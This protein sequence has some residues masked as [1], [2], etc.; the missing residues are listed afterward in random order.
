MKLLISLLVLPRFG[1][2]A[3][4]FHPRQAA[5]RRICLAESGLTRFGVSA[6]PSFA[7]SASRLPQEDAPALV[8]LGSEGPH[9][10]C[11]WLV[12]Y[13]EWQPSFVGQF[14]F[15]GHD[16]LQA[17]CRD[18]TCTGLQMM[19]SEKFQCYKYKH[20]P[21]ALQTQAQ[22]A[23]ARPLGDGHWLAQAEPKWSVLVKAGHEPLPTPPGGFVPDVR[24]RKREATEAIGAKY[25]KMAQAAAAGAACNWTVHWNTW[26]DKFDPGEYEPNNAHG[27]A[28][29]LDACCEDPNCRGIQLESNEKYQCYRY[30][31]V[32]QLTPQQQR[33]GRA[34]GDGKWLR[35][36]PERW[37]IF[38]KRGVIIAPP[39]PQLPPVPPH[40]VA[41]PVQA[42]RASAVERPSEL[43]AA[44][45]AMAAARRA[46]AGPRVP[47]A[48]APAS[49]PVPPGLAPLAAC[50]ALIAFAM[51][52]GS[53]FS[54][55]SVARR[56][57]AK[58][59]RHGLAGHLK[60]EGRELME[61]G[62]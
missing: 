6:E 26:T 19:S 44:A 34:L 28:H 27:G 25:S 39:V 24:E 55:E 57:I 3:S 31:S 32:P 36:N 20:V 15:G 41:V 61:G 53:Y 33:E 5:S 37:S 22:R 14:S 18:P 4:L 52:T 23:E 13:D 46:V 8:Q 48:T 47:Q 2:C 38:V 7:L 62:L 54:G 9:T 42:A 51:L 1:G 11:Q 43:A 17:C 45:A 59:L 30:S 16:C 29:C 49:H 35:H 58:S 56:F 40:S 12:H 60:P 21:W 50:F 10:S